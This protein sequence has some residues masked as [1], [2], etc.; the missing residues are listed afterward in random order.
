MST[1]RKT[2]IAAGVLFI[3]ATAVSLAGNGVLG[4]ALE[5]Q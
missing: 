3:L 4:S 5:G 1:D 2:A